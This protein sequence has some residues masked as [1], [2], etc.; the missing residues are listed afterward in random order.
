MAYYCRVER[1]SVSPVG[2]RLTTFVVTYPRSCIAEVKTHRIISQS[3]GYE[4]VTYCEG[5]TTPDISKNSASSRAIPF[6]RMVKAVTDSP[7]VPEWTANQ[8]GMQGGPLT[9]KDTKTNVDTEWRD[10]MEECS[11]SATYMHN[12]G[13]HKQDCNR[14]LEPFAWVT[15][16]LTSSAWDNFFALRCHHMAYPPFRRIARMMYLARRNSTPTPLDYGQWHLP[17]VPMSDQSKF[18]CHPG[19][20]LRP[21]DAHLMPCPIRHSA[22]RCAW[23]SYENHDKDGGPEALDRTFSRMFADDIGHFSPLEHQATP[24]RPGLAATRPELR[25][26][27]NGWLQARK[28]IATECVR[29]YSPTDEEVASWGINDPMTGN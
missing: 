7:Y 1:D 22:A 11:H 27:L 6:A 9:N 25:S 15:Q 19:M 13:I 17:F 4:E 18:L 24:M 12:Q 3:N 28:L 8:K 14:L 23:V 20:V 2:D 5:T 10:I 29:D 16:V 21:A 26:N